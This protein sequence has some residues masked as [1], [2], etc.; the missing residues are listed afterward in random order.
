VNI[1]QPPATA[2]YLTVDRET[3]SRGE[4]VTFEIKNLPKDPWFAEWRFETRAP[5]VGTVSRGRNSSHVWR[6]PL[7]AGGTARVKIYVLGRREPYD[8]AK[9]VTVTPRA[10]WTFPPVNAVFRKAGYTVPNTTPPVTLTPVHPGLNLGFDGITFVLLGWRVQSKDVYTIPIGGPNGGLKYLLDVE[11][12]TT[13]D[14]TMHDEVFDLTSPFAKANCGTWVEQ[15]P[16]HCLA[17]PAGGGRMGFIDAAVYKAG[18]ARHEAG[19]LNSHYADYV[20]AQSRPQN[21][22]KQGAEDQVAGPTMSERRFIAEV[23]IELSRR[24]A[25]IHRDR[26]ARPEPCAQW[27]SDDCQTFNGFVNRIPYRACP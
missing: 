2:P 17:K 24:A 15:P 22:L 19:P 16:V 26:N 13:V 4:T 25:A 20:Q 14:W 27:C 8:L 7:A 5:N 9:S 12:R 6:G 1:G 11:D 3:V 23:D 10:G 18:L 21:N